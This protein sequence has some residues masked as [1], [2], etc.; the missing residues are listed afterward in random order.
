ML[1][2]ILKLLECWLE[3]IVACEDTHANSENGREEIATHFGGIGGRRRDLQL[4]VAEVMREIGYQ[5]AD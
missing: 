2:L 5:L 1:S 4:E 3:G